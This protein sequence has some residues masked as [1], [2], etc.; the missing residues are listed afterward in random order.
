MTTEE[1][2]KQSHIESLTYEQRTCEFLREVMRLMKE[3]QV[4][5]ILPA[6]FSELR[7]LDARTGKEAMLDCSFEQETNLEFLR[8]SE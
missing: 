7:I 6:R 4:D 5:S 2:K 3:Y 8:F 1:N